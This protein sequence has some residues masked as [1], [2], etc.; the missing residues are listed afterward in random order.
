MKLLKQVII[1][2]LICCAGDVVSYFLPIPFPG[3]VIA[4][5]ML[6]IMLLAGWVKTEQI[7]DVSDFLLQNMSLLF[8]PSTVS[9]IAY[10]DV[11][12]N[13]LVPFLL[14]CLVST[15]LVFVMTAYTV[16][17]ILFITEKRRRGKNA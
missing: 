4:L 2:F 10:T 6:F 15:V 8:I 9:I 16:K 3:S 12:K 7:G 14:I 11:L 13:I 17:L 5:I 1:L